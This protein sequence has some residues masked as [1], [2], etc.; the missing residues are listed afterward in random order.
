MRWNP[1]IESSFT[2]RITDIMPVNNCGG[3]IFIADDWSLAENII[4]HANNRY[5]SLIR[6]DDRVPSY[7]VTAD[8]YGKESANKKSSP[9]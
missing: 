6:F 9:K 7:L 2:R 4:S 1:E 5:T 3:R 8:D